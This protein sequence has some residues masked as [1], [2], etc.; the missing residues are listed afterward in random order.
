MRSSKKTRGG[1]DST[2]VS[3]QDSRT[4]SFILLAVFG[5]F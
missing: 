2:A 5:E 4:R 3:E 1:K